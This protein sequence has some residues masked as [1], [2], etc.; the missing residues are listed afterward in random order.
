MA[1]V[2][3]ARRLSENSSLADDGRRARGRILPSPSLTLRVTRQAPNAGRNRSFGQSVQTRTIRAYVAR[4]SLR[5]NRA[6]APRIAWTS[7][8][9]SMTTVR[10]NIVRRVLSLRSEPLRN[11]NHRLA[12]GKT[13]DFRRR[14]QRSPRR[15]ASWPQWAG[16]PSFSAAD[17][18]AE[19]A[20]SVAFCAVLSLVCSVRRSCR[21]YLLHGTYCI[22]GLC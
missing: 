16:P 22:F 2:H 5:L 13:G 17:R 1:G 7:G 18:D 8:R 9:G 20:E 12:R 3:D 6:C 15:R 10:A 19:V 11:P 21:I 14:L 4:L